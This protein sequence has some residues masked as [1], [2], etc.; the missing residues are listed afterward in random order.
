M[1]YIIYSFL[2]TLSFNDLSAQ[3]TDSLDCPKII[4][5][6]PNNNT[7]TEGQKAIL[8]VKSFKKA[9]QKTHTLSYKWVVVNGTILE[10]QEERTV[11]IDTKYLQGQQIKVAV[12]V[13]GLE[14]GCPNSE[15]VTLNVVKPQIRTEVKVVSKSVNGPL[16]Y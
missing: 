4:I 14:E 9:F 7:V 10:G 2:L 6:V 5:E 8:T 16:R 12:L 11:Y 1:K 13:N 15:V 3:K